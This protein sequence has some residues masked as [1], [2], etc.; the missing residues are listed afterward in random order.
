MNA[1]VAKAVTN[2]RYFLVLR[3]SLSAKSEKLWYYPCYIPYKQRSFHSYTMGIDRKL[4][5]WKLAD[6]CFIIQIN[7]TIDSHDSTCFKISLNQTKKAYCYNLVL[8]LCWENSGLKISLTGISEMTSFKK[9]GF[10][11]FLRFLN[12]FQ[13]Y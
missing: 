1:A 12:K 11:N 2:C 8:P 13:G 9:S 7:V 10:E 5:L 4:T 6:S 3:T